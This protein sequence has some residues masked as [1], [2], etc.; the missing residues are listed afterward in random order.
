MKEDREPNLEE[1]LKEGTY[2]EFGRFVKVSEL[3]FQID[4]AI[5]NSFPEGERI[6]LDPN[7]AE[8]EFEIVVD[9]MGAIT[10]RNARIRQSGEQ[11]RNVNFNP[12]D[13]LCKLLIKYSES[14]P[15]NVEG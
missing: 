9:Y 10:R 12:S 11:G 8:I 15:H 1:Q 14:Q 7:K 2:G 6:I 4:A 13:E 3:S 5:V